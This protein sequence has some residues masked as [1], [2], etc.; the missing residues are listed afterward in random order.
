[1]SDNDD[2]DP[3]NRKGYKYP[4]DTLREEDKSPFKPGSKFDI[5]WQE[6]RKKEKERKK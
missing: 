2:T 1:M 4:S 6:D 5:E 3:G